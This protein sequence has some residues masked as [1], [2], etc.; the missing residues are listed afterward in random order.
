M[1]THNG[2]EIDISGA[3][4][5]ARLTIEGDDGGEVEIDLSD[6]DVENLIEQLGGH[7]GPAARKR[8][9]ERWG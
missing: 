5:G 8:I 2:G 7:L 9:A 3:I 1:R 6:D 4:R